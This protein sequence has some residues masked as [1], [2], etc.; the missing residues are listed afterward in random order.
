MF[1]AALSLRSASVFHAPVHPPILQRAENQKVSVVRQY[2]MLRGPW[3]WEGLGPARTDQGR[4]HEES[5]VRELSVAEQVW[6]YGEDLET[7]SICPSSRL[8][9]SKVPWCDCHGGAWVKGLVASWNVA[10]ARP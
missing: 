1:F 4:P 8:G 2:G 7:A 9:K 5:G 3:L 6:I 10:Q